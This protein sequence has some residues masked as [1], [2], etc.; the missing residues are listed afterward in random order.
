MILYVDH[1]E[2]SDKT[3]NIDLTDDVSEKTINANGENGQ[4]ESTISQ[5][6]TLG[7]TMEVVPDLPVFGKRWAH[8]KVFTNKQLQTYKCNS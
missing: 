3:N 5:N 4:E 7:E 6:G 2:N 1:E 8:F